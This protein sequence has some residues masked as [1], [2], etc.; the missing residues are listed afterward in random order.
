MHIHKQLHMHT[1]TYTLAFTRMCRHLHIHILTRTHGC[2]CTHTRITCICPFTF[3]HTC[4]HT[5][6]CTYTHMHTGRGSLTKRCLLIIVSCEHLRVSLYKLRWLY[7]TKLYLRGLLLYSP[8]L[9]E[10]HVWCMTLNNSIHTE[11]NGS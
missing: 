8:W 4:T 9:T 6:S 1:L 3:T 7:V 5:H 11:L 2:S 10:N